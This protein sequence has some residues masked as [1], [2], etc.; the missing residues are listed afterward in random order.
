MN[1]Q[2][3]VNKFKIKKSTTIVTIRSDLGG[4]FENDLFA[5]FYSQNDIL[6][7][8]SF[9]RTPQQNRVVERKNRTL[10]E[11]ART[12]LCESNLPK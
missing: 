8:F 9:P 5:D 2:I 7:E 1:F 10:Q 3:F 4:E 6:H 11:C 12:L